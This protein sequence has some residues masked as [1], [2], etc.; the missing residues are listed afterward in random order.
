MMEMS[1]IYEIVSSFS[2]PID[3]T[4]EGGMRTAEIIPQVRSLM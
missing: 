1:Y 2:V 4:P 3:F